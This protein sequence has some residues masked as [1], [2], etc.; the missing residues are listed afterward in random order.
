MKPKG[1]KAVFLVMVLYLFFILGF[2]GY[3]FCIKFPVVLW[4]DGL[5][6]NVKFIE[7]AREFLISTAALWFGAPVLIAV[8]NTVFVAHVNRKYLEYVRNVRHICGNAETYFQEHYPEQQEAIAQTTYFSGRIELL[9]KDARNL[10]PEKLTAVFT[11]LRQCQN[12]EKEFREL[13]R[14][15]EVM[16][17]SHN[18]QDFARLLHEDFRNYMNESAVLL[19]Q[20]YPDRLQKKFAKLERYLQTVET[21]PKTERVFK[22]SGYRSDTD[23]LL[24]ELYAPLET[25]A[26]DLCVIAEYLTESYPKIIRNN[27]TSELEITPLPE[28]MSGRLHEISAFLKKIPDSRTLQELFDSKDKK[29]QKY[30]EKFRNYQANVPA[31]DSCIGLY[32]QYIA[33]MEQLILKQLVAHYRIVKHAYKMYLPEDSPYRETFAKAYQALKSEADAGAYRWHLYYLHIFAETKHRGCDVPLSGQD[34]QN[35]QSHLDAVR[36]CAETIN[37]TIRKDEETA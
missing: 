12:L 16:K 19:N 36:T 17:N 18:E 31:W 15:C 10:R 3:V 28:E 14:R 27:S 8:A 35:L 24:A 11:N 37:Q 29:F 9:Q 23:Y 25:L 21:Q 26:Q 34:A 22:E 20:Y 4:D 30:R 33:D 13:V 6:L 7:S 2:A 5:F 32:Y 1:N